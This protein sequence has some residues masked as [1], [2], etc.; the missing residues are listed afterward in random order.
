M[1]THDESK[2]HLVTEWDREHAH[3]S[4]IEFGDLIADIV[5]DPVYA[6]MHQWVVQRSGSSDVLGIGQAHDFESARVQAM[7]LMSD[8]LSQYRAEQYGNQAG[9]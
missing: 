8:L 5:P 9:V 4:R 1:N 3:T 7:A 6:G 2:I